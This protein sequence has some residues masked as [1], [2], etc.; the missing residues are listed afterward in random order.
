MSV[1]LELLAAECRGLMEHGRPTVEGVRRVREVTGLGLKEA[2]DWVKALGSA[3][4]V[5][6]IVQI[7]GVGVDNNSV[8]QCNAYLFALCNDGSVWRTN[9]SFYGEWLAMPPIP[10]DAAS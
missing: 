1:D 9:T 10:Q 2:L 3:P 8:T 6:R 7:S 5:R 4:F